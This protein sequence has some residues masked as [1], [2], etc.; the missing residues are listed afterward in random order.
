MTRSYRSKLPRGGFT[1]IELLVV[2]AII[3]VLIG[4]LLPAV[5]KVRETAFR[6]QSENNL[7]QLA[8]ACHN[9]NDTCGHLPDYYG[10]P[11]TYPYGDG[12]TTGSYLFQLCPFV[13]QDPLFKSTYGPLTYTFSYNYTING[14]NYN[15]SSSYNYGVNGYQAQRASGIIKTFVSPLDPTIKGINAPASYMANILVL[16]Y[17]MNLVKITDGTSNTIMIAEGYTNCGET[18]NF[19]YNFGGFTESIS[20]SLTFARLWN[21][22]P[23]NFSFTFT[24]NYT[25]TPTSF[26]LTLTESGTN[27]PWYFPWGT[28]DPSSQ[29][30]IPFQVKPPPSNCD[31]YGAQASTFAG[32][33][34]ALADGS[35]R[36]V[37]PGVSLATWVAA[38]SPQGGDTLGSDW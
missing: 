17:Y 25:S 4:L 9:Y 27:P 18:F 10:F 35:V 14:Q 36:T 16:Q 33:L 7:H 3:A 8:L 32:V 2:M 11:Y 22:D 29:Q 38:G 20:E 30:T 1:L 21:Y 37:S 24:E 31:P 28:Y 19:N 5:Q 23:F 26:T 15:Y 13:E 34:V 12:T 6:I